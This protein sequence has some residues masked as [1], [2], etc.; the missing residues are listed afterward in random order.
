MTEGPRWGKINED[1]TLEQ[2]FLDA[3]QLTG[4]GV[5]ELIRQLAEKARK[6]GFTGFE[7][8]ADQ[9]PSETPSKLPK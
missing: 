4:K 8:H 5:G 3:D 1:E 9:Q 2:T 7:W 6:D